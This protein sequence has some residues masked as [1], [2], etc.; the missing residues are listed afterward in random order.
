MENIILQRSFEP[1]LT[2]CDF[3]RMAEIA[4]G[5]MDLYR[6]HW[7]ESFLAED[8][9]RIVCRF[10]APDSESIRQLSRGDG[11]LE[12]AAWSGTLHDGPAAGTV[13][14]VV[15]RSF[16]APASMDELQA[17]EDAAAWCLEQHRVQ[18]VRSLFSADRRRMVCLYR[19]PDAE[20]VRLAQAQAGMPV[21]RVWACRH[22]TQENLPA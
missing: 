21:D 16:D 1:G 4:D 5:C 13:T 15:E 14:V 8:G 9:H 22:F 17:R 20:S 10:E 6:A 2:Q 18:F 19:A 12:S 3:L 11:A 7:N